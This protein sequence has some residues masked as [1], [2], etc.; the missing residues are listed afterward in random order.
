MR[1]V[2][3]PL[4]TAQKN[5]LAFIAGQGQPVKVRPNTAA[6]LAELGNITITLTPAGYEKYQ[7]TGSGLAVLAAYQVKPEDC[8]I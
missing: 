3:K 8:G 7:V 4:T 2:T 6:S 5:A 1:N